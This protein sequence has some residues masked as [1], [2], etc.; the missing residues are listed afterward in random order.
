MATLRQRRI[1]ASRRQAVV[2]AESR[3]FTF[4]STRIASQF[5]D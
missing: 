2:P 5:P 3:E 4:G 1:C